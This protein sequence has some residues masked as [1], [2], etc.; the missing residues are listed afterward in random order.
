MKERKDIELCLKQSRHDQKIE[1]IV[2]TDTAD[3]RLLDDCL[4]GFS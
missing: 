4:T 3:S 2:L 1:G